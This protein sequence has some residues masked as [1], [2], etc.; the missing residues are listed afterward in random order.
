[1][2]YGFHVGA[3]LQATPTFAIGARYLSKL[4]FKYDEADA[5]F[6]VSPSAATYVLPGGNAL[7]APAGTTLAQIVAPFF[8]AGGA[9]GP[10][11]HPR[12]TL[13]HP[14]QFQV[15]VGYTG[16]AGTTLS[17]DYA[18]VQWNAFKE[19]VIE[20]GPSSPTY[21]PIPTV[22][23]PGSARSRCGRLKLTPSSDSM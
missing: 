23:P 2:A 11:Q 1:M 8:A 14:A 21:A 13:A 6:T 18:F 22:S 20:F 17:A 10:G 3:Y 15:G 9:L 5:T 7:G 16:F 4:D 19:L 12:T